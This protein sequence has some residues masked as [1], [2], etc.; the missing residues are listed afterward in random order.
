[1]NREMREIRGATA[2]QMGTTRRMACTGA[3]RRPP[4]PSPIGWARENRWVNRVGTTRRRAG[5]NLGLED[6]IPLGLNARF[7]DGFILEGVSKI[8]AADVRR[9]KV[10]DSLLK[11]AC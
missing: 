10:C 2:S 1:M 8:V 7:P 4:Q 5:P 3:K 9:R 6:A 11:S